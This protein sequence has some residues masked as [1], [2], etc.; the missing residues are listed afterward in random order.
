MK[1]IGMVSI[2][3]A[4]VFSVSTAMINSAGAGEKITGT[5]TK[6]SK[7]E[8]SRNDIIPGDNP[9]HKM[10]QWVRIDSVKYSAPEL[11]S[12]EDWGYAQADSYAGT[13]THSGY[14]ISYY[15]N[16][17]QT[18]QKWTGTHKTTINEDGSWEHKYEGTYQYIGGTGKFQDI[19]GNG[20]YR[21]TVTPKGRTEEGE[22]T[23]E[24]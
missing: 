1:R 7:K 4:I 18:F 10:S 21:G 6:T 12:S 3:L 17:D 9:K 8:I 5:Y 19:K 13:G 20:V 23:V 2:V 15:E 14:T 11:V 24:L 16:G 22:F